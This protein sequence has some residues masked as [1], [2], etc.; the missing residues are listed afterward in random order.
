MSQ[1]V[2]AR[3]DHK[4]IWGTHLILRMRTLRPREEM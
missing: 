3:R 1:D 4:G 2:W